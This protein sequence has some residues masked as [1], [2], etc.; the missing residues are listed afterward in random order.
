MKHVEKLKSIDNVFFSKNSTLIAFI[1]LIA[2]NI[3]IRLPM[4]YHE[5]GVDTFYIHALASSIST[6]G[7]AEWLIHPSSFFGVYPYSYPS[8]QPYLLSGISQALG[9]SIENSILLFSLFL[10]QLG[11]FSAY[12]LA[13]EFFEEDVY[14]LIAA[15]LFSISPNLIR[16]T[17][18]QA[19]T[20]GLFLAMLPLVIW[21]FIRF[22]DKTKFKYLV[23][24][25]LALVFLFATHRTSWFLVIILFAFVASYILTSISSMLNYLAPMNAN[26]YRMFTVLFLSSALFLLQFTKMALFD[27]DDYSTGLYGSG[28]DFLTLSTNLFVD[29]FGKIGIMLLLSVLGIIAL[30][31]KR[32]V[33]FK[34]NFLILCFILLLSLMGLKNYSPLVIA[35][36][37]LILGAFG[38]HSI[39]N[40]SLNN[41]KRGPVLAGIFIFLCITSSMLF[42]LFMID[43][44]GVNKESLS[45]EMLVSTRFIGERTSGT[46]VA[47]N[48]FLANVITSYSGIPALP[49]GGIYA[50]PSPPNQIAY[51]FVTLD[52]ISTRPLELSEISPSTD[53]FYT[54]TRAPNAKSEW[55]DIMVNSYFDASAKSLLSKYNSNIIIE[56]HHNK[57]YLYWSWKRSAMLE[58]LHESGNKIYA[59]GNFNAFSVPVS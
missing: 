2:L 54:L 7:R 39:T 13:K 48:G 11:L 53:T 56:H 30:S 16:F 57:M 41:F 31:Y 26:I 17:Y 3:I 5:V 10:G 47:N 23:L 22:G 14:S 36:F 42:T 46:V 43:H 18:W 35:P 25:S 38:I 28:T 29:Y 9:I 55:A 15:F 20:R 52:E 50:I 1:I 58:S 40:S 49:L 19:S 24:L 33:I 37:I 51:G 44:W 27:L 8:T 21:L 59:S 34:E 6:F 12:L 32:I 45:D 4:T